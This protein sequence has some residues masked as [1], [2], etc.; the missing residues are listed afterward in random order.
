MKSMIRDFKVVSPFLI[1]AFMFVGYIG[2]Q[3]AGPKV[4]TKPSDTLNVLYRFN[5]ALQGTRGFYTI[6]KKR[7]FV[8]SSSTTG[9]WS[10]DSAWTI[11]IPNQKDTMRNAIGKP[12]YDSAAKSYKF[13]QTWYKLSP[14][15]RKNVKIQ[16]ITI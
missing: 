1:L 12:V 2:C 4:T 15:E 9:K 5:G 11:Q 13:N 10:I 6:E 16:I 7:E 14:E 8:D 3:S